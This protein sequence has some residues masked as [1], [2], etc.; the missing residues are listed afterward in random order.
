MVQEILGWLVWGLAVLFIVLWGFIVFKRFSNRESINWAICF[1]VPW[2]II[3]LLITATT[4]FSKFHLFWM[5]PLGVIFPLAIISIQLWLRLK[6]LGSMFQ[7]FGSSFKEMAQQMSQEAERQK[8]YYENPVTYIGANSDDFSHLDLGWY[9]QTAQEITAAAGA[10]VT[11]DLECPELSQVWRNAGTFIRTLTAENGRYVFALYNIRSFDENGKLVQNVKTVDIE[12]G[13]SDGS[14]L[15]TS[16]TEGINPF[17]DCEGITVNK[18]PPEASWQELFK[19]HKETVTAIIADNNITVIPIKTKEEIIAAQI[20][21]HELRANDPDYDWDDFDDEYEDE[22]DEYE[23]EDDEYEDDDDEYEDEDDEYED[24]DDE[25]EDE[26]DEYE[27]E[28][29]EYEDEDDEDEDEDDEYDDEEDDN[30]E[31][32]DEDNDTKNGR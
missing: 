7:K 9:D 1:P 29:D 10:Q 23:D 2:G 4:N 3:S 15:T 32:E 19:L 8:Q 25:Y 27:D 24:D 5:I 13:F 31:D 20:K 28:D 21:L 30:E 11:G 22:D 12:T 18:L 14:F 26:D 17:E 16:N 6:E